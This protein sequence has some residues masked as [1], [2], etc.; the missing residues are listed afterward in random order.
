MELYNPYKTLDIFPIVNITKTL[1][2]N[3]LMQIYWTYC[4]IQDPNPNA[5]YYIGALMVVIMVLY[6][7]RLVK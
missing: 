6:I 2:C 1:Y 7:F 4:A 3:N 5:G